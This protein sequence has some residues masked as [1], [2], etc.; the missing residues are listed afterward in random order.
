MEY[1]YGIQ[2]LGEEIVNRKAYDSF[3]INIFI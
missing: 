1:G 2:K 3:P